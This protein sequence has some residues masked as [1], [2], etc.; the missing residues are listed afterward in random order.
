MGQKV[1]PTGF[2]IGIRE[3]WRSRWYAGKADF[4]RKLIEDQKIRKFIRKEYYFA[5]ISCV[6]IERPGD[7]LRIILHSARPGIIIGRKGAKVDE[8][9]GYLSQMCG[10]VP[11]ELKIQEVPRPELNAQLVAD[12]IA[13]QLTKRASFGRVLKRALEATMSSGAIGIKIMMKGRLGG[14]EMARK[15]GDSRGKIPLQT[16]D[17]RIDYA[18]SEAHTKTGSI[19]VKVWIYLGKYEQEDIR[20]APYAKKGKVQKNPAR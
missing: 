5:G 13:E 12:G 15:I 1:N 14:A 10:G 3:P 6:E 17:A 2:R 8:L 18:L 16:L 20:N 9:R 4:S 7:E 19:G 11:V